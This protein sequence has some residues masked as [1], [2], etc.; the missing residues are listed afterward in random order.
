MKN[1]VW[2][3]SYPRSGNT[4]FRF[5][6]SSLMSE[7]GNEHG[8]YRPDFNLHANSRAMF[9]ELIGINSSD[10]TL[11]EINNLKPNVFKLLSQRSKDRIFIKTHEQ[12]HI[13]A[14]GYPVFPPRDTMGCLY[15]VRNPLDVVVSNAF[16]FSQSFD[17]TITMFNNPLQSLHPSTN[18]ML[19]VLE[20]KLGSWSDHATSWIHSGLNV[21]VMR[22]EDMI[23]NPG[24]AFGKALSFLHLSYPDKKILEAVSAA[25]FENLKKSEINDGFREKLQSCSSFFRSG[26][27]GDWKTALTNKQAKLIVDTHEQVMKKLG[28]L[29]SF[30]I[31]G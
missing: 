14:N 7:K 29:E 23:D 30:Q 31:R 18:N 16:Y 6:L 4:W 19:P 27:S 5:F 26:K 22:Y 3:A 28:Y 10:L 11:K 9:D 1:L 24:E 20:E 17:E 13:N 2:L 21:H 25:S 12:F 8:T 15:F